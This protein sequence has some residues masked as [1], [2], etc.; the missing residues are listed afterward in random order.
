MFLLPVIAYIVKTEDT[1]FRRGKTVI[2]LIGVQQL[3][4][5][6]WNIFSAH[7]LKGYQICKGQKKTRELHS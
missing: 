4:R 1:S 3:W 6:L 5:K 7:I 2:T